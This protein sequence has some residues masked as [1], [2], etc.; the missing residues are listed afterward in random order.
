ML[1]YQRNRVLFFLQPENDPYGAGYHI[2]QSKI[3]IGS[4]GLWGK[5]WLHGTQAQLGFLPEQSTDFAFSVL[6]EEFGFV[7]VCVLL[8]IFLILAMRGVHIALNASNYFGRLLAAGLSFSFVV[9]IVTN[10]AM[11]SGLLPVV[12]VPL[13]I[14]SYGGTSTVS[15][16]A[17]FGILIA[18][19]KW[20]PM[21][22]DI[23]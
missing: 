2:M 4:G 10:L 11:A 5:G 9:Y 13:P 15:A 12:G 23:V 22:R 19:Q 7:G 17:V 20:H 16:F 14:M 1:D 8:L 21:M 3:A 6:A 18:I